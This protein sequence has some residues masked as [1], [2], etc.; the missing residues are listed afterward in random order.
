LRAVLSVVERHR[1]P[2]SFPVEVRFA[3]GDDALL[4]T[5]Y[6]RE[7]A[8]VAVHQYVGSPYEEYFARVE[9]VMLDLDGRPHWG[10]RH[11]ADASVLASRY[12]GWERFA[13]VRSRL[14]PDGVFLNDHLVRTLGVR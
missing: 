4:S 5:A 14:D 11:R 12:P 8:Y 9:E 3:A 6:G 13:A 7:T 2:V 10:K 1:L